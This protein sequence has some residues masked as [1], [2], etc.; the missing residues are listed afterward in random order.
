MVVVFG[1]P[2][3]FNV[4]D[5]YEVL[6]KKMKT[7]KKP[8][9]PV[10]PS[11]INAAKEI[12]DFLAK[13]RVNFPDEV[14]LG[15]ALAHIN[16]SSK[17][18]F[19]KAQMPE[20][21]LVTIRSIINSSSDGFLN[22]DT[23]AELL[24]AAGIELAGQMQITAKGQIFSIQDYMNFP[25]VMKVIGPVHKKEVGGVVDWKSVVK[26]KGVESRSSCSDQ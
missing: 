26:G 10:L 8:I 14:S 12:E 19:E 5:V 16:Q 3:I 22:P 13:G 21:D 25:V 23:C 17:I 24:E 18:L 2:G 20:M 15:K 6:D 1:S 7:S 4:K 9:F 11:V